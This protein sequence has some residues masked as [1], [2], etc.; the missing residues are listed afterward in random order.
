M[1]FNESN[2][3]DVLIR[4]SCQGFGSEFDR[5]AAFSCRAR[6]RCASSEVVTH[7]GVQWVR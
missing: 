5:R 4:R 2:T 6:E 3:L 1:T 7:G